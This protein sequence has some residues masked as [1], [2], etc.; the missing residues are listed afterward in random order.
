MISVEKKYKN[1]TD[2]FG[3]IQAKILRIPKNLPAAIPVFASYSPRLARLY[4]YQKH[5][6]FVR[7]LRAIKYDNH[8]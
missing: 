1:F 3:E 4:A 7:Q 6:A 5:A 2:K 8:Q